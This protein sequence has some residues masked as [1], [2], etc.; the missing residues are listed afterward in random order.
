MLQD[1]RLGKGD[2]SVF[3]FTRKG[4]AIRF[5]ESDIRPTG[6]LS[7]G[8]RGIRLRDGDLAVSMEAGDGGGKSLLV[9]TEKG[10]GKR[11]DPA[12]FRAQA[13]GGLGVLAQKITSKTGEVIYAGFAGESDQ[14]LITTNQG[15][16]IRF[17]ITE[18]SV[19]GRVS[20][21]V[22]F[23]NL[24]PSEKVTGAALID[25][26]GE[27]KPPPVKG[28]L[29]GAAAAEESAEP[30]SSEIVEAESAEEPVEAESSAAPPQDSA[31][32]PVDGEAAEPLSAEA[33]AVETESS[34]TESPES[35]KEPSGGSGPS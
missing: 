5:K 35:S 14:L 1:V 2:G 11:T 24:K 8:V 27:D 7:R 9:V 28:A 3:I 26:G 22:R 12:G 18:I 10:F 19:F 23:I 25:E 13:R 29:N 30:P 33:E 20:Q 4:I 34:K 31:E 21:G 15:Q 32:E 6:R 16:T 17:A